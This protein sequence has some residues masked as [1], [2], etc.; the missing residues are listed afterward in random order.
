MRISKGTL[1][2]YGIFRNRRVEFDETQSIFLAH[3]RNEGGKSTLLSFVRNMLFGYAKTS[4][5]YPPFSK[6]ARYAEGTLEFLTQDG[7]RGAI[8]RRWEQEGDPELEFSA[9]LD[10]TALT[11]EELTAFLGGGMVN[12]DFFA[13]FF[14]ISYRE[15][16]TG[17][18]R[19]TSKKLSE[20]VYG[21]AFGNA[22]QFTKARD[23]LKKR[24][25][26]L[27]L[28][29]GKKKPQIQC[30]IQSF[31]EAKGSRGSNATD[32]IARLES[33]T[34][35]LEEDS[36]RASR[37]LSEAVRLAKFAE[38]QVGALDAKERYAA[39]EEKL[40]QLLSRGYAAAALLE[41]DARTEESAGEILE[42]LAQARRDAQT[43]KTRVADAELG[44]ASA[45]AARNP[46]FAAR[47]DAI[48]AQF[49]TASSF[50]DG[51]RGLEESRRVLL[52][53]S[54]R[55]FEDLEELG[56]IASDATDE[57]R[58]EAFATRLRALPAPLAQELE[59]Q[60]RKERSLDDALR[61]E[62]PRV[63]A[64]RREFERATVALDDAKR[65][66]DALREDAQKDADEL[67]EQTELLAKERGRAESARKGLED[68]RRKRAKIEE[69]TR[70]LATA[71]LGNAAG[72]SPVRARLDALLL[73]NPDA[74]LPIATNVLLEKYA[75]ARKVVEERRK[76]Y[77]SAEKGAETLERELEALGATTED[78]EALLAEARERRDA[79][80]NVVAG[81]LEQGRILALEEEIFFNAV[82]AFKRGV[83]ETDALHEKRRESAEKKGVVERLRRD[84]SAKT[85]E[86]DAN[87]MRLAASVAAAAQIEK[88]TKFFLAQG[89][90]DF[91]AVWSMDALLAW[92]DEWRALAGLLDELAEIE[93]D[94]EAFALEFHAFLSRSAEIA[95]DWGAEFDYDPS[96]PLALDAPVATLESL[97]TRF[98]AAAR[99]WRRLEEDAKRRQERVVEYARRVDERRRV[100]AELRDEEAALIARANERDALA[101]DLDLFLQ[102]IAPP[103]RIEARRSWNA[104]LL[105][106]QGLRQWRDAA[107]QFERAAAEF[108]ATQTRFEAHERAVRTLAQELGASDLPD[109]E[110]LT[111]LH[112][113]KELAT[114][115]RD[116]ENTHRERAKAQ[117]QDALLLEKM[118]EKIETIQDAYKGLWSRFVAHEEEFAEFRK[119]AQEYRAAK[120]ARD[121]ARWELATAL[122][123][124][125]RSPEFEDAVARLSERDPEELRA[126]LQEAAETL[127]ARSEDAAHA[128]ELLF[129]K[130]KD[131]E[132]ELKKTGGANAEY[133]YT[134]SLASLSAGIEEYAPLKLAYEALNASLREFEETRVPRILER[135]SRLFRDVTDG[136]YERI[137][138]AD[139][140]EGKGRKG[141]GS[142]ATTADESRFNDGA[143]MGYLVE[144]RG[145]TKPLD[146]LSQGT[147]E[148]LYLAI[149]LA[150]VEEYALDREPLPLLADDVLVQYDDRRVEKTIEALRNFASPRQQVILMTHHDATR[151]AFARLV[152]D[153]GII[154]LD[155]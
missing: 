135:T 20:T 88:E 11:R 137:Y 12:R 25:E 19:L 21:L 40:R 150:L 22:E 134:A 131:L 97:L 103:A 145:E 33:E 74:V 91:C 38:S 110:Y 125:A 65:A 32:V 106:F 113:W 7:R 108:E 98:D 54:R 79:Q 41:C 117:A 59:S 3:G 129:S 62:K 122:N 154:E 111:P 152:G 29:K 44:V 18:S 55:L 139:A 61:D 1:S 84:L 75:G 112:R 23:K 13:N 81:Y 96:T 64:K 31:L 77:E 123:L 85:H 52:E 68:Y 71:A 67:V 39:A 28:P 15:I 50:K 16:A 118:E 34:R 43:L 66:L 140:T 17:E 124:D 82:R 60:A 105:F 100:E 95:A 80:W 142:A 24:M 73:K 144:T 119:L 149:R 99:R 9:R 90:F 132:E 147:R 57:E 116:A 5:E 128:R 72:D 56:A 49:A 155:E 109:G 87:Q 133:A 94:V 114:R 102:K 89:G 8:A 83:D 30:A 78:V 141:R 6:D 153:A 51:R 101:A 46:V 63:D 126:A 146:A 10:G 151:D 69:T 36:K 107:R 47:Y 104:L 76:E 53:R 148:Q 27:Y 86:R 37:T 92:L 121:A 2:S 14:G 93:K 143:A 45:N 136:A 42:R 127:A 70:R 130:R 4:G 48:D 26:A 58:E 35:A 120:S 115:A 138:P